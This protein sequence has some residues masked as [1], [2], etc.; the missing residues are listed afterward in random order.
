MSHR[1]VGRFLKATRC[2]MQKDICIG[3]ALRTVN[4]TFSSAVFRRRLTVIGIIC[5]CFITSDCW[6]EYV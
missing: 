4:L 2:H 3:T 6:W 5:V 1:N